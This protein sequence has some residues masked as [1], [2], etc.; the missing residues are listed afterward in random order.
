MKHVDTSVILDAVKMDDVCKL[1][2]FAQNHAGFIVCPFHNEK[3]PSLKVYPGDG[4]WHCFGCGAGGDVITFV[5][6][7]FSI[8]FKQAIVRLVN[9]FGII[10]TG[11]DGK[12]IAELKKRR[13]ERLKREIENKKADNRL[14][15][16]HYR[17]HK[18]TLDKRPNIND[19]ELDAEYA[20]A[21]HMLPY[22]DYLISLNRG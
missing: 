11:Q 18:I 3:T 13:H 4:G 21:L 6:K 8:T 22:L 15:L 2:G 20:D 1:Y 12:A 17:L 19:D 14:L 16:Q 9:D 7:L 10:V 5:M